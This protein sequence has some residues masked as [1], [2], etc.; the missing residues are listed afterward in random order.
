MSRAVIVQVLAVLLCGAAAMFSY[1]LLAKHVTGS[2]GSSWFEAVCVG[3]DES[4]AGGVLTEHANCAAVLASPHSFW[5]PKRANEPPGTPHIPIAFLGLMYFS[6]LGVW[7]I[8]VGRPSHHR[9]W[10]HM[11]TLMWVVC[12][13]TGSLRYTY[14]M[15]TALNEW[16]PWCLFIHVL[17]FLI[18]VCTLLLWPRAPKGVSQ[19]VTRP[20]T[21]SSV[22]EK[23]I[24]AGEPAW[25][26]PVRSLHPAPKP[27]ALRLAGTLGV[28]VIVV[29]GNFGQSAMLTARNTRASLERCVSAVKRIRG[30]TATLV[31][32]YDLAEPCRITITP[33]D[34]VR[35]SARRDQHAWDLVVF[36]DFLCPSCRRFADFLEKTIQPLFEKRLRVVFKHYPLDRQCNEH[37]ARTTHRNACAA[38]YLAAAAQRRGGNDIFWRAHDLLFARQPK[39]GDFALDDAGSIASDLGLD[40]DQLATDMQSPDVAAR[41]TKDIDLARDC[42][43][44]GTPAVFLNGRRVDSLAIMEIGFWDEMANR[45][46][47]EAGEKR[48]VSTRRRDRST[49][50]DNRDPTGAP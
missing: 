5:P 39:G 30:D 6:L 16:C 24:P 40:H 47:I 13:L 26:P 18:V 36:S 48:P 42:G 29:Y 43:V 46:W 22:D 44:K 4:S 12:G 11:I 32:S 10:F 50:P 17:N 27:S 23:K 2:T 33:D 9:R 15:F 25:T 8:G 37:A 3:G 14:I 20:A 31:K 21:R 34:P 19:M 1:M 38:A 41:V 28:M 35:T 45:F 49:T 7:L